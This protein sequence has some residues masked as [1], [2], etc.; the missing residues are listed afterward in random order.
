MTALSTIDEIKVYGNV[1]TAAGD[2]TLELLLNAASDMVEKYLGYNPLSSSY[3]TWVN[4]NGSYLMMLPN[5][6]ITAVSKVMVDNVSIPVSSGFPN[7]GYTFEATSV[8]LR[9][10]TFSLGRRNVN[11]GYTAGYADVPSLPHGIRQAVNELVLTKYKSRD[12][13]GHRSKS[14]A[15]ETVSYDT[16]EMT[17]SVKGYLRDYVRVVPV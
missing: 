14:L 12:W 1:T 15:G 3:D 16:A 5:R 10:Y 2:P 6:P 7:N 4:G 8:Y 11:I 17:K 9:G 13:L